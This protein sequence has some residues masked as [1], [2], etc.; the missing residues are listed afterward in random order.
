MQSTV[1]SKMIE[2]GHNIRIVNIPNQSPWYVMKDITDILGYKDTTDIARRYCENSIRFCDISHK[3]IIADIQQNNYNIRDIQKIHPATLLIQR[4]DVHRLI[5][6]AKRTKEEAAKFESWI[7]DEVIENIIDSGNY[8]IKNNNS[9]IINIDNIIDENYQLKSYIDS[10]IKQNQ[11][12]TE[13]LATANKSLISVN[14]KLIE[15]NDKLI[16]CVSENN[17]MFE[18]IKYQTML[19]TAFTLSNYIS[20][21]RYAKIIRN[22]TNLQIRANFNENTLKLYLYKEVSENERIFKSTGEPY[23]QYVRGGFY[24]V[25]KS[26][27]VPDVYITKAGADHLYWFLKSKKIII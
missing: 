17:S 18:T 15:N 20:F 27:G 11:T 14:E 4:P 26:N 23:E 12:L 10:M 16:K 6:S 25:R 21:E 3:E 24:I 5:V 8:N 9:N 7:F 1:I 19:E 13:S 22:M 2:T